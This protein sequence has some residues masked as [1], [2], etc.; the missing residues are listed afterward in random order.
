MCVL[1]ACVLHI[2][3]S[4]LLTQCRVSPPSLHANE[5]MLE[6]DS[7]EEMDI[8][9]NS[10]PLPPQSGLDLTLP[11]APSVVPPSACSR[12][13]ASP[14]IDDDFAM[15]V[16]QEAHEMMEPVLDAETPS[17]SPS[18]TPTPTLS[19]NDQLLPTLY[20]GSDGVRGGSS[21]I[22]HFGVTASCP[23]IPLQL[24]KEAPNAVSNLT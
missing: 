15:F 5:E 4:M 17:L 7:E 3:A 13:S 24:S 8:G 2:T 1:Y 22:Q 11:Q 12:D 6:D 9:T 21:H 14:Y 16:A 19:S 23:S 18:P 20:E 10:L